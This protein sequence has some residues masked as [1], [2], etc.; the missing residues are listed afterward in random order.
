MSAAFVSG[1]AAG[2]IGLLAGCAFLLLVIVGLGRRRWRYEL[3][4][5]RPCPRRATGWVRFDKER[6][7][8]ER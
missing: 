1:V 5:M 7:H 2:A 6:G 3:G 4:P 8:R